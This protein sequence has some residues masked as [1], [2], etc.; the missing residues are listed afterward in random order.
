MK[1]LQ[2][3]IKDYQKKVEELQKDIQRIE[4]SRDSAYEENRKLLNEL[5]S[6][7]AVMNCLNVPRTTRT[8]YGGTE[9]MTVA[10]RLFAWQAGAN[11]KNNNTEK[12]DV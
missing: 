10:S 3:Q 1:S 5:N 2:T 7:H 8:D 9:T 12:E 6:I 11:V 4:K